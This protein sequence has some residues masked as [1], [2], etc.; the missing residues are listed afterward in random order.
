MDGVLTKKGAIK[1]SLL[2][3]LT[4]SIYCYFFSP[5]LINNL[6]IKISSASAQGAASVASGTT[7]GLLTGLGKGI[8]ENKDTLKNIFEENKNE[9]KELIVDLTYETELIKKEAE[10]NAL[11]AG[12]N[13]WM[14]SS[15]SNSLTNVL[16]AAAAGISFS[17]P[18]IIQTLITGKL[19]KRFKFK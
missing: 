5:D 3:G 14:S 7:K 8:K 12:R 2:L 19:K 11:A 9:I 16:N 6:I 18:I 15:W 13:S 4:F 17:I 1:T 10:A